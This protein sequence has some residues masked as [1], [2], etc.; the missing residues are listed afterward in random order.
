M[1]TVKR[2]ERPKVWGDAEKQRLAAMAKRGADASEI[3]ASLGR[4]IG[5]VRRMA[6][7]MKLVLRKRA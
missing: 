7:E 1:K 6:R 2:A 5:S 4:H 3:S